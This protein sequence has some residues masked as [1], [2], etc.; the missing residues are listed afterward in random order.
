MA[1][2][3][4]SEGKSKRGGFRI[5][6]GRKELPPEDSKKGFEIWAKPAV[7]AQFTERAE[8]MGLSRGDYLE[9]LLG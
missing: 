2:I 4:S 1:E 6:A 3:N 9:F 5:G 8:Q 7:F